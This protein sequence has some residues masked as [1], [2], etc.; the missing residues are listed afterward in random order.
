MEKLDLQSLE[1][2]RSLFLDES[3]SSRAKDYWESFEILELYDRTFAQRIGWKWQAVLQEFALKGAVV[4]KDL[5][6][7]D[8][9]CGSGIASRSF[10]AANPHVN[11]EVFVY[12]RSHKATQFAARAIRREFAGTSVEFWSS[13]KHSSWVTPPTESNHTENDQAKARTKVLLLSHVL[14]ELNAKQLGEIKALIAHAD[15]TFWV[16]PGTHSVSR[17][18]I[19]L[20]EEFR[21]EHTILAPCPH[22]EACPMLFAENAKHWCH[23][24]AEPPGEV[25]QSA[26]WQQFSRSLKIDLRS[27]S[28]S[29]LILATKQEFKTPSGDRIL[30]RVKRLKPH[31]EMITCTRAGHID[32]KV[33]I[34]KRTH[35]QAYKE[36]SEPSFYEPLPEF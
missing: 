11:A 10:L 12:D 13:Q 32:D 33:K 25:F 17:S 14:N 9:G 20:R 5:S 27:L 30:G 3:Q 26:F 18:L 35:P 21:K 19:E 34:S 4:P 23:N 22:Q 16:E 7:L 31:L 28:T 15:L 2:L 8:W 24:F 36:L 1:Q 29:F 6:I